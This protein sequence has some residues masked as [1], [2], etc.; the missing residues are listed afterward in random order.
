MR[1]LARGLEFPEGPI[2]M[3]DG[4]V[5]VVEIKRGT[6][7]RVA[8]DGRVTVVAE[9]GGGPNG[10]AIGPDGAAYVCNNGG[11]EWHEVSGFTIPGDQPDSYTG[12]S[13]QRVDL[14]TGRVDTVYTACDGRPLRGPNDLVFHRDGGFWFPGHGKVRHGQRDRG[15][16]YY[17]NPDGSH[18]R[19]VVF[20]L[21][22]RNGVGLSPNGKRLYV[23]ETFTGRVW[24]WDVVRPGEL[25]AGMPLAPGGATLLA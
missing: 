15:G 12:G 1:E 24:Q 20:P 17:A 14:S 25:A 3:R 2:A 11:F 21:D 10:A 19:E 9:T 23:A 5:L 22:S 6:L 13:I 16:L 18:S 8:S 4:S 7:S